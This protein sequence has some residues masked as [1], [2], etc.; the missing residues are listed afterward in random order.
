MA[1]LWTNEKGEGVGILGVITLI[2]LVIVLAVAGFFVYKHFHKSTSVVSD[3]VSTT[4]STATQNSSSTN[5]SATNQSQTATATTP[6]AT[7]STAV[8]S[9]T[10]T[11]VVK[12]TQL[13]VEITIPNTIDDLIYLPGTTKTTPAA[14]TAILSTTALAGLDPACGLDS[15]KTSATI[16]GIGELYEYSGKYTTSSAPDPSAVWTK[17]FPSFYVAYNTPA[18]DCSKTA[19]TNTKAQAQITALKTALST[20]TVVSQ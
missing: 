7:T 19:T 15:S 6:T 10:G 14:T 5:T 20:M 13:G 1:R 16:Q 17:Q 3:N 12:V 8:E 9:P 18:S 4:Q 11:S 2:V